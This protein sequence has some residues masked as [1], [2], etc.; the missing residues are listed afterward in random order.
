M[1]LY[2]KSNIAITAYKEKFAFIIDS[3]VI[4]ASFKAIFETLWAGAK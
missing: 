2:G 3:P 4:H 1:I